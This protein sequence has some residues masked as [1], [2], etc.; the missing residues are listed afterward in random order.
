M[1]QSLSKWEYRV[2]ARAADYASWDGEAYS[3]REQLRR[4]CKSIVEVDRGAFAREVR[5]LYAAHRF[6]CACPIADDACGALQR[7]YRVE[8]LA[9]EP[10]TA[11]PKNDVLVAV[12]GGSTR[13]LPVAGVDSR[14]ARVW[15]GAL[16]SHVEDG[17]IDDGSSPEEP[18]CCESL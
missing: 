5:S 3:E 1:R 6:L 16:A 15:L 7:G 17:G 11:S 4:V 18:A 9:M 14:P 12:P 8:L 2:A 13:R 10:L